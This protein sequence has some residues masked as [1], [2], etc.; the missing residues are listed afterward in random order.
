MSGCDLHRDTPMDTRARR[1]GNT[2]NTETLCRIPFMYAEKPV[3]RRGNTPE[4]LE[5]CMHAFRYCG[6]IILVS[7]L[8]DLARRGLSV[9]R[10]KNAHSYNLRCRCGPAYDHVARMF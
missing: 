9:L 2:G 10:T 7:F 1:R 4:T 5:T 6:I 8:L 3:S